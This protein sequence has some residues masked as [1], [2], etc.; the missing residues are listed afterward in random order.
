MAVG[1]ITIPDTIYAI[2]GITLS[3]TAAGLRYKDRD[4]LV[5]IKI[6]EAA[7][8]A[9]V[10]TKNTFCAAPVRVLREHF[11]HSS[12][13]YLITNTGNANAGTG[14][15]GIRRAKDIC[16]ALANKTSVDTH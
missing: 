11:A 10:T 5:I 3:A 7:T 8:T 2:D 4:D 14:A 6:N 13:R 16:R 12:P 15:D 1:D 9:V